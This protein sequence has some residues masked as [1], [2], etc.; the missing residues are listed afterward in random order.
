MNVQRSNMRYFHFSVL[1]MFEMHCKYQKLTIKSCFTFNE[2]EAEIASH[3]QHQYP[4]SN[5]TSLG[6]TMHP[7][8]MFTASTRNQQ[9]RADS[10]KQEQKVIKYVSTENI[11]MKTDKTQSKH[12]VIYISFQAIEYHFPSRYE[13]VIIIID[14]AKETVKRTF[15]FGMEPYTRAQTLDTVLR[16]NISILILLLYICIAHWTRTGGNGCFSTSVAC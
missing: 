8:A 3:I 7:A 6:S 1:M 15:D 10:K 14:I 13:P 12:Y 2:E 4:I 9:S 5:Y 16:Y 11:D